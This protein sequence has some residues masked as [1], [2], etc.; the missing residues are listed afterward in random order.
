[1]ISYRHI[2]LIF[3]TAFVFY[4]ALL[5]IPDKNVQCPLSVP[6]PSVTEVEIIR[7]GEIPENHI[8]LLPFNEVEFEQ[9]IDELETITSSY[10]TGHIGLFPDQMNYYSNLVS[11]KFR[12]CE[13]GFGIGHSSLLF[14]NGDRYFR[15]VDNMELGNWK[16]LE[17]VLKRKNVD[18]LLGDSFELTPSFFS[19][20]DLISIDGLHTSKA[21]SKDISTTCWFNEGSDVLL[22]DMDVPDLKRVV[23]STIMLTNIVFFTAEQNANTK[24]S[25][26]AFFGLKKEFAHAKCVNHPR[27]RIVMHISNDYLINKS[28][29]VMNRS[30]MWVKYCSIWNCTYQLTPVESVSMENFYIAKLNS[31]K[32]LLLEEY[33]YTVLVDTDVILTKQWP[34]SM[35]ISNK[36]NLFRRENGEVHNSIIVFKNND[37][38]VNSFVDGWISNY[39]EVLNYDNGALLITLNRDCINSNYDEVIACF[40][41]GKAKFPAFISVGNEDFSFIKDTPNCEGVN[42]VFMTHACKK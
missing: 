41:S 10:N 34:M 28:I 5:L 42:D 40:K 9:E 17:Y 15:V 30:S 36:I 14:S 6:T 27:I 16:Q 23:T 31:L 1:M 8:R 24:F 38:D 32:H 12:P 26:K 2:P 20:C 18:F 19:R 25:G 22:D 29:Q 33:D 21:I 13:I 39:G 35:L 4:S 37:V 7:L 3:F 11:G